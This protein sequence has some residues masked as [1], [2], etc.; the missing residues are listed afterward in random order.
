MDCYEEGD[1][2]H[3]AKIYPTFRINGLNAHQFFC[4]RFFKESIYFNVAVS[5]FR[6]QIRFTPP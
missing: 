4:Y 5:V 6:V 3:G 2:L 1:A